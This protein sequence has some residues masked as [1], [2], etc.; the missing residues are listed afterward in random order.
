M[1]NIRAHLYHAWQ[2]GEGVAGWV[3]T[4]KIKRDASNKKFELKEGF[5]PE[6]SGRDERV[7]RRRISTDKGAR[8]TRGVHCTSERSTRI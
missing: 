6:N 3:Q 8:R 2:S 7:E 5:S 4:P 1:F